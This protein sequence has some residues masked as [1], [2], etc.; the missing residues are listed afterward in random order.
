MK[1]DNK[2]LI[3][4]VLIAVLLGGGLFALDS[5]MTRANNI[6][7]N[8]TV[9]PDARSYTQPSTLQSVSAALPSLND[10]LSDN[11]QV[12]QAAAATPTTATTVTGWLDPSL[13]KVVIVDGVSKKIKCEGLEQN[14]DFAGLS[15]SQKM[16]VKD[17]CSQ[18]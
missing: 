17:T 14:A 16:L 6:T 12:A 15:E 9:T 13:G 10:F 7:I 3:A 5:R 1:T 4:V 18:L 11:P 8:V 2:S